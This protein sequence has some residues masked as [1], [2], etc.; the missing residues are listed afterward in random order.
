MELIEY[1]NE[2]IQ[3]SKPYTENASV[4]SGISDVQQAI[5]EFKN[6]TNDQNLKIQTQKLRKL[7]LQESFKEFLSNR[8]PQPTDEIEFHNTINQTLAKAFES[9]F[10]RYSD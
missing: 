8:K 1:A 5:D 3:R 7:F 2:C 4:K 10:K 9:T 6:G